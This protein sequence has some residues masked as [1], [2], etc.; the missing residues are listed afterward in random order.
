MSSNHMDYFWEGFLWPVSP[1]HSVWFPVSLNQRECPLPDLS[2]LSFPS[3]FA[4]IISESIF[5]HSHFLS[6]IRKTSHGLL[7]P[8]PRNVCRAAAGHLFQWLAKGKGGHQG[9]T[10]IHIISSNLCTHQHVADR[11]LWLRETKSFPGY[12]RTSEWRS[13][14]W[15]CIRGLLSSCS[16]CHLTTRGGKTV[17]GKYDLYQ[18]DDWLEYMGSN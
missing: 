2:T 13:K 3:P 12:P 17:E 8:G 7:V 5:W 14:T 11:K 18:N 1:T 15:S 4:R 6:L 10:F 16:F 9:R